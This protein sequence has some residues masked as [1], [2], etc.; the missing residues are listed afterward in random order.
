MSE[1][2]CVYCQEVTVHYVNKYE[3][4]L[5]AATANH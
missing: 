2:F 5:S 3:C 4:V 1:Q